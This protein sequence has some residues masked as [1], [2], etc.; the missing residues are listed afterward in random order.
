MSNWATIFHKGTEDLV[1]TPGFWLTENRSALHA[2]FSGNW[3]CNAGIDGLGGLLLDKWYHL[4]YTLSDSE[5][6]LDLYIDSEWVGFYSIQDVKTQKVVFNDGPLYIGRAFANGFNGVISNVRY[7]NWRLC[8][9]ENKLILYGS[10]IALVIVSTNKYLSIKG[11]KYEK[12]NQYMIVGNGRKIDLDND[13]WT[14]IGQYGTS[15]IAG[16]P[17]PLNTIIGFNHQ[18]TGGNLHSHDMNDGRI[19][20]ISKQQKVT[21]NP[22]ISRDNDFLI[23]RYNSKSSKDDPG[24]LMNGDIICLFHITTNKPA[25]LYSH[26]VL[27]G[28]GTQEVSF[29]GNGNDENSKWRIELI[30]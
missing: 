23:Q 11:N 17:V 6:R 28:D 30:D 7:F 22:G 3:N 8:A 16:S 5:K 12:I 20:P 1:R 18:A 29:H 21:I 14:V 26:S 25:A 9:Q 4:T 2:R 27:F 19:T 24:Y 10:K 13:V 15:V